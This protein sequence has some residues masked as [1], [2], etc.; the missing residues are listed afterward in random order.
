MNKA[1]RL[2]RATARIIRAVSAATVLAATIGSV[3]QSGQASL[4][5]VIDR[6]WGH[7][8]ERPLLSRGGTANLQFDFS[9]SCYLIRHSSAIAP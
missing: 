7:A 5:Y 1:L 2:F 3:A 8:E 4:P 6:D 9:G